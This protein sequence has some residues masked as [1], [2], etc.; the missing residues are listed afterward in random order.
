MDKNKMQ[1]LD[2]EELDNVSGGRVMP[3]E[4]HERKHSKHSEESGKSQ[5]KG[6]GGPGG[7]WGF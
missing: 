6:P 3:L 7:H 1:S 4:R 2:L 5:K